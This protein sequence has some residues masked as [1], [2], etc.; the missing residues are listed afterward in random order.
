[1][2]RRVSGS[3]G[4]DT[5]SGVVKVRSLWIRH[6]VQAQVPEVAED[7]GGSPRRGPDGFAGLGVPGP[8]RR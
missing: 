1:M 6:Q 8:R 2:A 5:E 4:S 7:L 3:E